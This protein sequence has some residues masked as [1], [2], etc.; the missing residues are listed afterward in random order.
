[1]KRIF[2]TLFFLVFLFISGFPQNI[3]L[4]IK[5]KVSGERIPYCN[6]FIIDPVDSMVVGFDVSSV[7]G[8]CDFNLI[9]PLKSDKF[10][11]K[12]CDLHLKDSV[13][14]LEYGYL[15]YYTVEWEVSKTI[16]WLTIYYNKAGFTKCDYETDLH[17]CTFN[18]S[19]SYYDSLE[20]Y[21]KRDFIKLEEEFQREYDKYLKG[22]AWADSVNKITPNI[23]YIMAPPPE[24]LEIPVEEIYT[25]VSQQAEYPGG[26]YAFMDQIYDL[27]VMKPEWRKKHNLTFV[28]KLDGFEFVADSLAVLDA[29]GNVLKKSKKIWKEM[30]PIMMTKWKPMKFNGK[31]I[32][33]RKDVDYTIE[34]IYRE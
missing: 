32:R 20:S 21:R 34:F 23:N 11:L 29:S 18:Y 15:W 16:K 31:A 19:R 3:R 14:E 30:Q 12:L 33:L 25:I 4:E 27:S 24:P 7:N 8:E 10:L 26:I 13:V 17:S 1:M 28:F 9:R 5:E 2:I 22:L 6:S